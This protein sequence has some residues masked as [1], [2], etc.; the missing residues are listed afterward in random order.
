MYEKSDKPSLLISTL[1]A[2]AELF[3]LMLFFVDVHP[4]H[5]TKV[6][7]APTWTARPLVFTNGAISRIAG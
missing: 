2:L 3:S 4:E 6:E 1:E 5:G 7:V